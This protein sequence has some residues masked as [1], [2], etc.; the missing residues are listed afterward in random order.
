MK[1]FKYILLLIFLVSCEGKTNYK[2]PENLIPKDQMIDLLT[3][4]HLAIGA[5]SVNNIYSK[6]SKKYMFL[7]F[8]K[9]KIDSTRFASSNIYYTSN[10][11]EYEE[12]YDVI[13]KRIEDTRMLYVKESDSIGKKMQDS[14]RFDRSS[15]KKKIPR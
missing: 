7:V 2:K 9:H 6:K 3:D 11:D 10:T 12:M 4:M 13:N 5:S 14:M 1:L 15:K 8:E